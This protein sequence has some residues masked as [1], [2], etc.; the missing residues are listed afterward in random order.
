MTE[1]L[2]HQPQWYMYSL[3]DGLEL[4]EYFKQHYSNFGPVFLMP[5][6]TMVRYVTTSGNY[7]QSLLP[8]DKDIRCT[9]H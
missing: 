8:R 1:L 4:V 9:L 5:F 7:W 2:I 6:P 3:F